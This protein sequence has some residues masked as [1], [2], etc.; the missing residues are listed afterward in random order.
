M[1]TRE[2]LILGL[3]HFIGAGV[4]LYGAMAARYVRGDMLAALLFAGG[5][6]GMLMIGMIWMSGDLT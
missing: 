3:G 4:L 2:R 6:M 5:V 1:K